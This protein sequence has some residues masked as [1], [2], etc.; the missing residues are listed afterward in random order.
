MTFRQ[1]LSRARREKAAALKLNTLHSPSALVWHR[2]SRFERV[3]SLI[4]PIRQE[5]DRASEPPMTIAEIDRMLREG[6]ARHLA[7]Q[8][9]A[10]PRAA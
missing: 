5:L 10:L 1:L 4:E 8:A 9:A 6:F 3:R 2:W 7:D